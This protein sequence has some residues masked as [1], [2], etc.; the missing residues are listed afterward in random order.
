M[1]HKAP[2]PAKR[3]RVGRLETASDVRRFLARMI[4]K[5]TRSGGGQAVNDFYKISLMAAGLL[6]AIEVA[7]LERR[8]E[9]LEKKIGERVLTS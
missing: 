8:V 2:K 4:K 6:K 3:V 1:A 9:L 7:D 5:A